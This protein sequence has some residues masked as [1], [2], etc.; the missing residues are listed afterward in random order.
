MIEFDKT[1]ADEGYAILRKPNEYCIYKNI[2]NYQEDFIKVQKENSINYIYE[3]HRNSSKLIK[4]EQSDDKAYVYAIILCKRL[5]DN[6]DRK[7]VR[8]IKEHIEQ[9]D[10]NEVIK[11][12]KDKFD[13]SIYSI[14]FEEN[15]KV[16][17]IK[18]ENNV[19]IKFA[20][21]YILSN[22]S[23]IRGYIAFYNY[24]EKIKSIKNFVDELNGKFNCDKLELLRLYL[25]G[26]I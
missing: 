5:Y 22:V 13:V 14:G 25:T 12:I 17:L 7:Y 16:S 20:G 3:I 26:E 10:E 24:C 1:L 4:K 11:I 19:D 21:K 9:G 15:S 6:L 18:K 2:D 23:M 8:K